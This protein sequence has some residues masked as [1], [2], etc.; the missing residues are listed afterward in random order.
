MGAW[1][2]NYFLFLIR[3]RYIIILFWLVCFGFGLLIGPKFPDSTKVRHCA[4]HNTH[5]VRCLFVC[6]W[7]V[8]RKAQKQVLVVSCVLLD[9]IRCASWH[10]SL[11]GRARVQQGLL[12]QTA[13]RDIFGEKPERTECGQ[14]IQRTI[15]NATTATHQQM[16]CLLFCTFVIVLLLFGCLF[17]C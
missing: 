11:R 1:F 5:C 10:T 16:V 2:D 14:R 15:R 8:H 3:A 9:H 13:K 12:G 6:L 17:A 7:V 4:R